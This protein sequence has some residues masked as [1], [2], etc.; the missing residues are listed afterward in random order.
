MEDG[1][2]LENASGFIKASRLNAFAR[3]HFLMACVLF[4]NNFTN[5]P[6]KHEWKT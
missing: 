5:R 4:S 1:V 3:L 6:Y 2:S